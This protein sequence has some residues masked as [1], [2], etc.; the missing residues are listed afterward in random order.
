MVISWIL[1]VLS[2]D[3]A[4]SVI[5]SKTAKELWDSLE[6]RFGRSN[7]A[8]L[9]H[10]QKELSGLVQGN[11]D[12]AGY[13]TKFKRLWDKLDA[14]NVIIC[15]SCV[16]VCKGKAKLTKSLEDQRLIQFLMGLNDIY[17][18]ARG[19]ILM[20]N[21]LPSMDVAY[22]LLLQDENQ[23]K[24]MQMHIITLN[25]Y[26]SWQQER[27]KRQGKNHQK[28]RNQTQR[29]AGIGPKFNNSGQKFI[30]PQ[31]KFKSKKKYNPNVSCTYC[32]KT[33]HTQED[34]YRIIGFPDDFEFTYHKAYQNQIKG[35]AVVANEE[36]ESPAGQ[37]NELNGNNFG[38]QL[39]KEQVAEM[40]HIYKQAKMAQAGNTG[41]NANSVAG[42][43]LKYSGSVFTSLKSDTWI[44][45]S[46]ASEHMCFDPNSFLFLYPLP[47][48]LNIS[49]PNSFKVIV[50]HIGSISI[51][52]GHILNNVLHAPKFK[53]NLL[54]V[55]RFCVQ[56]KYDVLFTSV[57]CVLQGLSM[58]SPQ[59]FGE[60]REG[61]YLLEP[62]SIK[63][64][65][66]FISD[67]LSIP[68]GRNSISESVSFPSPV[69]V[70]TVSD[71]K[72]WHV[73]LGH[74]PFSAMKHLDFL[75][76]KSN[77]DFVCD[78][79]PKARQTRIP[80]PRQFNEKVKVIRSDNALEL[81]KGT[82]E[83]AFLA[84]QGILHQLSCVATPQ[85]NG[86]V[87]RK[88]RHLLETARGL[89]FQSKLHMSYWGESILTATHLINKMP[90]SVLKGKTPYEV[91]FQK[92]PKYDYLRNFG[93]LCYASTLAQEEESLMRE[94]Q[95][96]FCLDTPS[97]KRI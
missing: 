79:C 58:K 18:Q 92:K 95:P 3:I 88:H 93:C 52:P 7:G 81:G 87:E 44:I 24:S 15:C 78:V 50:T 41:I 25:Q 68:K 28:F 90:S 80:F 33:G 60:V 76:C 14:L 38:Q 35:N 17:A 70:N 6:Q 31:Q 22:S 85:Q 89:M 34:C 9:Y 16:C 10:L 40:M 2:K 55:H 56:F 82:Q 11:S 73:R 64:K 1:N 77:S 20:M 65:G 36:H 69:L 74:L 39:S 91:L 72:L 32:G 63:S 19:S 21:P 26:H 97:S 62:S 27:T 13:F 61:L 42:T 49:L 46:G 96:V 75:H 5:Y 45:D 23:R 47:V 71:V 67:V 43:I 54:S 86:V 8:K 51:L 59:A 4:D 57:E 83:A 29:G 30:K 94:Q 66:L 48:P 12:I 53:Y 37:G 84:S